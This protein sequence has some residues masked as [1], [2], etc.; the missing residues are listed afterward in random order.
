MH[1]KGNKNNPNTFPGMESSDLSVKLLKKVLDGHRNV[2]EKGLH[3][4]ITLVIK[5]SS[6]TLN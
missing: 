3:Y 1:G 2:R 4:K 6:V 5:N